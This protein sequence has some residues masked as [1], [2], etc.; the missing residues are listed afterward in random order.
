MSIRT[1]WL[2]PPRSIKGQDQLGSQA[3]CEMTYSQLLP[4]ITNVTER[5]RY[6]SFYT[7]VI[8]S[9]DHR[10]KNLGPEDY[11]EHFR[12]AD[13]LY[14]LI[15][16][17]EASSSNY[18]RPAERMVGR[19]KLS[20]AVGRLKENGSLRLSDYA[21][22]E[23]NGSRYFQNELGG[24]GQYYAGPLMELGLCKRAST[25]PWIQYSKR[26]GNSLAEA[27]QESLPASEFWDAVEKDLITAETLTRLYEFAPRRILTG[28][29]EHLQLLDM[30]LGRDQTSN[31]T[32]SGSGTAERRKTLGLILHLAREIAET[33]ESSLH[34]WVFRP[35]VYASALPGGAVWTVPPLLQKTRNLWALYER[36][37]LLSIGCQAIFCACLFTIETEAGDGRV[38]QSVEAFARS[39][40]KALVSD[41]ALAS[42]DAE[43]FGALVERV[44]HSGPAIEN[45]ENPLHEFR[46]ELQLHDLWR[47][48]SDMK[49]LIS[50]AVRL[51]GTLAARENYIQ[52]GYGN[53]AI[54]SANLSPYPINL[55]SFGAR[56]I[57]WQSMSLAD[58]LRDLI[59]WVLN[60]HLSVA[61]RKL[62]QTRSSSFHLRP[63][64][65][66]LQV[67]NGIPNPARTLPRLTQAMRILEDLC[68][69]EEVGEDQLIKITP[70]GEQLLEDILA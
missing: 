22:L 6:F 28:S 42:L 38:Y 43:T 57:R 10:L 51:L 34:E 25:G 19:L 35:A 37:D 23:D 15:A 13:C 7:W 24:L 46:L 53:L 68:A 65:H 47:S 11:V 61:L 66:G 16:A 17:H 2:S 36:N 63:T 12:R 52:A 14:T 44:R 48:T 3:P 5:A 26:S 40:S 32:K 49:A 56:A 59:E 55:E 58:T 69:L 9:F 20:P 50:S 67:V 27:V 39:Y 21:T 64:E 60:A 31:E 30:M 45:F 62:A 1:N 41:A 18:Q 8:W 4:G 54:A 29:A 33:E 70:L